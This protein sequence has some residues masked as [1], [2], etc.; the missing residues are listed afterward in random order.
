MK[1][2]RRELVSSSPLLL[3]GC[4]GQTTNDSKQASTEEGGQTTESSESSTGMCSEYE[5]EEKRTEA[6][7]GLYEGAYDGLKSGQEEIGAMIDS[8]GIRVQKE[9]GPDAN[10]PNGLILEEKKNGDVLITLVQYDGSALYDMHNSWFHDALEKFQKAQ[11]VLKSN[12]ESRSTEWE[13]SD[14]GWNYTQKFVNQCEIKH[15]DLFPQPINNGISSV[16]HLINA[17]AKFEEECKVYLDNGAEFE[18]DVPEADELQQDAVSKLK[19]AASYYPRTPKSLEDQV[20]VYR[21]E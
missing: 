21:S 8:K 20:L 17:A 7:L 4:I 13:R 9:E 6:A 1:I 11:Q 15:A 19:E 12:L 3:A 2:S 16:E 10:T 5:S 18:D 14:G